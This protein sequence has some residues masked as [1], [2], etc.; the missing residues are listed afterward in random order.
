MKLKHEVD[1]EVI[2][3]VAVDSGMITIHD[4]CVPCSDFDPEKDPV[5][6]DLGTVTIDGFGGDG[7]YEVVGSFVE[8]G[9]LIGVYID[10]SRDF[11]YE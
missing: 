6:Y 10:F 11:D 7:I 3:E 2:G 1:Y 8:G 5:D 4:P 9:R